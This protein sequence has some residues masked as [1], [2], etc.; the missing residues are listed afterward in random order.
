MFCLFSLRL[1]GPRGQIRL[2]LVLFDVPSCCTGLLGFHWPEFGVG[3]CADIP[4]ISAASAVCLRR[5]P[6][7]GH[8]DQGRQERCQEIMQIAAAS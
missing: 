1:V 6:M 5:L 4:L 7:A 3:V 2:R 8:E